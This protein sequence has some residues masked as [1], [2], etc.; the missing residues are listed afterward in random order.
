MD[1]LSSTEFYINNKELVDIFVGVIFG[2]SIPGIYTVG[3]SISTVVTVVKLRRMAEWREQSSSSASLPRGGAAVKDV[4]LTRML[5]A[6][7]CVFLVCLTPLLLLHIIMPFVPE[8]NMNGKYNNTYYLFIT[9]QQMCVYINYSVNFF[10][11]YLFVTKFRQTVRG[12]FC[13]WRRTRNR[14]RMTTGIDQVTTDT[15]VSFVNR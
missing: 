13:G 8:L 7:S 12:M 6:T 3:V 15:A 11:Y 4:S 2:I 5:I 1:I 9:T 10:V 14:A